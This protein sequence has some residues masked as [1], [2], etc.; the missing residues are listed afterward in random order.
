MVGRMKI[1]RSRLEKLRSRLS[2]DSGDKK[3]NVDW[4][5]IIHPARLR[6]LRI[7]CLLIGM[8]LMSMGMRVSVSIMS[9]MGRIVL[10]MVRVGVD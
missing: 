5:R 8:V 6:G 7:L 1:L 4:L 3:R 10:G 9:C 2:G